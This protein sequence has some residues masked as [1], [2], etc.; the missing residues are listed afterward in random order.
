MVLCILWL[1]ISSVFA[2][3]KYKKETPKFMFIT[4]TIL[5]FLS[6]FGPWSVTSISAKSQVS[7]LQKILEKNDILV[8]EKINFT[9][10][11]LSTKDLEFISSI[12][13]YLTQTNKY[14][15]IKPWFDEIKEASIHKEK[16]ALLAKDIVEEMGIEYIGYVPYYKDDKFHFNSRPKDYIVIKGYDYFVELYFNNNIK[17]Q[18]ITIKGETLNVSVTF[19]HNKKILLLDINNN[20]QIIFDLSDIIKLKD[21]QREISI[22]KT[23][24]NIK[25]KLDIKSFYGSH[26]KNGDKIDSIKAILL[27]KY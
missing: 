15:N 19:E 24:G 20:D 10:K 22:E 3:T 2:L 25:V 27:I 18:K 11:K 16:K 26:S 1:F 4:F 7:R 6:S 17:N 14:I 23:I 13:N 21:Q 8:N 5:L 9:K 12:V